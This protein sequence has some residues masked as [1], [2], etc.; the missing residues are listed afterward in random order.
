MNYHPIVEQHL[1][2]KL[3]L[4]QYTLHSIC[5]TD[6][7]HTPGPHLE[8]IAAS[9]II[10]PPVEAQVEWRGDIYRG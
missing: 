4:I 9:V 5:Y 3:S 7:T 8:S 1:V 2:L 10:F 6:T